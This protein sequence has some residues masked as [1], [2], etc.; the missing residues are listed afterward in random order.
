MVEDVLSGKDKGPREEFPF[1]GTGHMCGALAAGI[2]CL[3]LVYGRESSEDDL[4]YIDELSY[5]FHR[6][7]K[8]AFRCKECAN[9]YEGEEK[10]AK[11]MK[12]SART[13]VE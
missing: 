6:R 8:E 5:E 3:G 9:L 7:F 2:M 11:I 13:A 4:T 12:F 1:V 10:C